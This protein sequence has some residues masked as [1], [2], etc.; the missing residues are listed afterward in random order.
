M[1]ITTM[2]RPRRP[3]AM[4]CRTESAPSVAPTS[5]DWMIVRLTGSAPELS[6]VARSF[7]DCWL[8]LPEMMP[9]PPVIGLW[10]YGSESSLP[11]ESKGW[12]TW[13]A[14]VF[15]LLMSSWVRSSQFVMCDCGHVPVPFWPQALYAVVLS[16][17]KM[18]APGP[19]N[20]KATTHEVPPLGSSSAEALWSMSAVMD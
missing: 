13:L 3:A 9:F 12:E 17:L 10:M 2:I 16:V 6:D 19:L 14:L 1:K 5:F 11:P 20:W 8:K 4:L 15:Q 18:P 7:A